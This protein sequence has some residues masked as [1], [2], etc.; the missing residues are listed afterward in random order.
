AQHRPGVVVV[1]DDQDRAL[2]EPARRPRA[3]LVHGLTRTRQRQRDP[4]ARAPADA[5]GLDAHAAT[6]KLG[7][8]ADQVEADPEATDVRLAALTED[9]E[10]DRKILGRDALAGVLDLQHRLLTLDAQS[11]R[12]PAAR[13]GEFQ[14]VGDE[15]ARDLL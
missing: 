13:R 12:H 10:D 7:Q 15:V 9:L 8:A 11:H 1:F 3:G 6:V 14:R 4:E 5:I 2:A